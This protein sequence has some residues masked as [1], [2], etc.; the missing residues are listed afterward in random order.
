MR[1]PQSADYRLAIRTCACVA[2]GSSPHTTGPAEL[3]VVNPMERTLVLFLAVVLAGCATKAPPTARVPICDRPQVL[4]SYQTLIDAMVVTKWQDRLDASVEKIA[5]NKARYVD[6]E[7]MT[8]VPRAIVAVI[9][10]KE[11]SLA[12]DRNLLNGEPYNKITQLHPAGKGPWPTWEAAAAE[13]VNELVARNLIRDVSRPTVAQ[14]ACLLEL[15]NGAGYQKKKL[16]TPY[17]WS[18]TNHYQ[19]GKF[20]ERRLFFFFGPYTS[21]YDKN[22]VSD[23]LGAMPIYMQLI[24]NGFAED[25]PLPEN[26][27]TFP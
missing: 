21:V 25:D 9:H 17:L 2:S 24:S 4:A 18:G 3:F 19:K 13:G 14:V 20:R 15:Y 5:R 7:R 22:L 23:Q 1:E 6:V 16:H 10:S 12:F 27:G 8:G 11:A 26:R